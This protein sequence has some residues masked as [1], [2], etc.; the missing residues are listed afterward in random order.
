VQRRLRNSRGRR[1]HDDAPPKEAIGRTRAFARSGSAS[2]A[3]SIGIRHRRSRRASRFHFELAGTSLTREDSEIL[4]QP[5]IQ[6]SFAGSHEIVHEGIHFRRRQH[7]V[8]EVLHQIL[9]CSGQLH[10]C[11]AS[12]CTSLSDL[13]HQKLIVKV[14]EEI[15]AEVGYSDFPSVHHTL[16]R[17][18]P[19]NLVIPPDRIQ[20]NTNLRGTS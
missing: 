8:Q 9:R 11:P 18:H 1:I 20:N 13:A 3:R 15:L 16:A 10:R 19:F 12:A 2:P 14:A 6:A 4:D 5:Q 17:S 7:I